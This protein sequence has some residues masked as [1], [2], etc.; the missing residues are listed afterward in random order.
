MACAC[1]TIEKY[2]VTMPNGTKRV[3]STK[4]ERDSL[5]AR[6]GTYRKAQGAS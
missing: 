5:I 6:G 4:V 1:R 2:A 3:V